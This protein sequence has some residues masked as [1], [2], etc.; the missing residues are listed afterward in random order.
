MKKNFWNARMQDITIGQ[1]F[2]WLLLYLVFMLIVMVVMVMVPQ[3]ADEI[4]DWFE[5]KFDRIKEFF[6]KKKDPFDESMFDEVFQQ[7]ERS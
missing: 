3:N 4:S 7:D 1:S 6:T 2:L 5:S